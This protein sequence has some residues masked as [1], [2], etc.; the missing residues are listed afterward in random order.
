MVALFQA[1]LIL[2]SFPFFLPFS[3]SAQT[4][5]NVLLILAD[6]LARG[7]L[8]GHGNDSVSTPNLDRLAEESVQFDRF[9]VSPAG[10]STRASLLTGR[11][12]LRTGV[13]GEAHRRQ[14]MRAGEMTMAEVFRRAGYRTALFGKWGK[15]R[16][17]PQ[18]PD[19]AGFRRIL[20][21]LRRLPAG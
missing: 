20:G 19:R 13:S 9:Y 7:D 3:S 6:D 21:L 16:A 2:L 8:H 1:T 12:A 14:V 4:P 17:I 15:R 10:A 11:Y 18:R 5:P